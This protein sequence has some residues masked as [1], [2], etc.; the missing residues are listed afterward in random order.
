MKRLNWLLLPVLALS[1]LVVGCGDGNDNEETVY[2]AEAGVCDDGNPCTLN[3]CD[4]LTGEC[5]NEAK[6]CDDGNACTVDSCD[7]ETGACINEISITCD[8]NDLCTTDF[9]IPESG[10]CINEAAS[11]SDSNA[12]T[13][14]ACD[15][16]T[17]KCLNESAVDCD[18]LDAC[19]T[20]SCN[21]M[22]GECEYTTIECDDHYACTTDS[23]DSATGECLFVAGNN[24]TACDD[25]NSETLYDM[26][27]A[28]DCM[29]LYPEAYRIHT[30]ALDAPTISF[31]GNEL[32][33]L[34]GQA[35]EEELAKWDFV[36]FFGGDWSATDALTL[37]LGQGS[38]D[39]ANP[40]ACGWLEGGSTAGFESV[41]H[42]A[43]GECAGIEAG[44]L[45]CFATPTASFHLNDIAPSQ[46]LETLPPVE[47]QAWGWFHPDG[48]LTGVVEGFLPK[49]VAEGIALPLNLNGEDLTAADI[50]DATATE[51]YNGTEGWWL[52][53]SFTASWV[54]SAL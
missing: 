9:C 16:T 42:S 12:C 20:D 37:Q 19:T 21:A 51:T 5:T 22:S 29:G 32:N 36:A 28:G 33:A 43:S 48:T 8:D 2:C 49:A 4:E 40:P 14:D 46:F 6:D 52:R 53:F 17:G 31:D 23:C 35:I 25:D 34:I 39:T 38:C 7:A 1:L 30:V 47:G 24:G 27:D 13:T 3:S 45:P 18:D 50:I 26:C 10:E 44:N 15:P 11:C 54:D 41:A